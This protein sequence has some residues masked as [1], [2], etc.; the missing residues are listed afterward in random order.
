MEDGP[1]R[2]VFRCVIGR[3]ILGVF[4]LVAEHKE[5]VLNVAE[6]FWRGL[7]LRCVSDGGH[8]R[9]SV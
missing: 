9:G 8:F 7:P 5:V 3:G 1:L 6:A 4:H 2:L